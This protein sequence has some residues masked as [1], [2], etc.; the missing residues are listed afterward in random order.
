M[1]RDMFKIA[2]NEWNKALQ[3][4]EKDLYGLTVEELITLVNESNK[5]ESLHGLIN[6]IRISFYY[7]LALGKRCE[8]N[9]HKNRLIYNHIQKSYM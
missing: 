5:G 7:G 4:K 1:K 3:K 9:N 8:K 6:S 2:E